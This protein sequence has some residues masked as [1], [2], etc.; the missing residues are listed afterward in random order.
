VVF[1][2][3]LWLSVVRVGFTL[4]LWDSVV[5]VQD[6]LV[7]DWESDVCANDLRLKTTHRPIARRISRLNRA[8]SLGRPD[9]L[10]ILI[11]LFLRTTGVQHEG[12]LK[13]SEK[14]S[15]GR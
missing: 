14:H 10:G 13:V 5:L 15:G 3:W 12:Q 2:L 9:A 4:S 1:P 8:A 6:F 7:S 11:I